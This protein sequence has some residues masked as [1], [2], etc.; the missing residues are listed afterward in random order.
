[1]VAG[2]VLWVL[3]FVFLAPASLGGPVSL[4]WVSGTSMEP[5][6]HTGDLAIMYEFDSYEVGDIVAFEIPEGGTVI[7]RVVRS[8]NGLYEFRGDNKP[9]DDQWVLDD[10]AVQGRQLFSIPNAASVISTL[11]Q[12]RVLGLLVGA[13]VLLSMLRSPKVEPAS[14]GPGYV[15]WGVAPGHHPHILPSVGR[16]RRRRRARRV[17]AT[18]RASIIDFQQRPILGKAA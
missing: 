14:L 3:W 4:I 13:M 10:R 7:H 5:T 11:G 16:F 17:L 1:M 6:L 8:G 2:V 15:E 12:P 9:R 18:H